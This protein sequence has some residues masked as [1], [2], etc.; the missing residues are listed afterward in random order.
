MALVTSRN[1]KISS[2]KPQIFAVSILD[3]SKAFMFQFHCENRKQWFR[4]EFLCSDTD[5]LTY[6]FDCKDLYE[7]LTRAEVNT[8]FDFY[9]WLSDNALYNTENIMVTN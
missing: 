1:T 2:V 8:E 7:Q 9:N 4:C 3:L 5:L 6:A